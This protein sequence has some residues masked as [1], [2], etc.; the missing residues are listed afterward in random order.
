MFQEILKLEEY[1][2]FV[3]QV[4]II[5]QNIFLMQNT[6]FI[7]LPTKIKKPFTGNKNSNQIFF[8]LPTLIDM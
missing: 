5:P 8:L 1:S 3:I 2:A 4:H 6:I 7:S